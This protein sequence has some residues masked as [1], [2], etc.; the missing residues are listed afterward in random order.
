VIEA[1]PIRS[2]AVSTKSRSEIFF[3][4]GLDSPSQS[5]PAGQITAVPFMGKHGDSVT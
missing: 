2:I 1:G 3:A 4:K 5:Q